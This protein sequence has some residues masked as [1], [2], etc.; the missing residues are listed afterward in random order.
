MEFIV[1]TFESSKFDKSIDIIFYNPLNIFSHEV[2]SSSNIIVIILLSL[3]NS[4]K[5][6]QFSL[7]SPFT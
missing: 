1:V 2:I 3:D 7:N 6:L 5:Y 4:Q